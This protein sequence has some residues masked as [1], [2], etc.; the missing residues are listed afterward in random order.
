MKIFM[1]EINLCL[2]FEQ[3]FAAFLI[4]DWRAAVDVHATYQK[5]VQTKFTQ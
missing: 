5:H 2:F 4:G 1:F 3:S